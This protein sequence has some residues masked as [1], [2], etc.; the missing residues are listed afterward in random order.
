MRIVVK[1]PFFYDSL[2]KIDKK[3]YVTIVVFFAP[4]LKNYNRHIKC[5][6]KP[7]MFAGLGNPPFLEPSL[8]TIIY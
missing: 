2:K 1:Y 5:F 8:I 7:L 6:G 3:S 4:V